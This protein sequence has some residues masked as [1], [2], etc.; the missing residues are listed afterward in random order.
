M[1]KRRFH[2]APVI[3]L[4]IALLGVAGYF[5]GWSKALAIRTIEI[6]AAGNEAIVEPLIVPTDLHIGLP[7]ARVSVNR[8]NTDLADLTWIKE[9]TVN[10]RWLAHDVRIVITERRAVA[11]Y[12]DSQGVTQYFDSTGH[13]FTAPNPPSGIP[14]ID[15]ATDSPMA[16]TAIATF[17]SQTPSDLTG[18]LLSLAVDKNN[19]IQ[20][21]TTISGYQSLAISWGSADQ[22][23]LKVKV[24][25]QLLTLP[26]NKKLTSVD[27]S[28][29][30]TPIVK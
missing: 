16:R 23:S 14:T 3:F 8:I 1:R 4:A 21:T 11:Q 2:N 27:L 25:R 10:R 24:L 28:S 26:E 6:S 7:I 9:I 18:N 5:L 22:I 19:E 17:L 20:L 13:K 30:L 15:F 12:Q 29:P